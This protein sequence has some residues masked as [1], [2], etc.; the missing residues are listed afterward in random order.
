[1]LVNPSQVADPENLSGQRTLSAG[2]DR[3]LG[4]K[5][6]EQL[7][8]VEIVR[9]DDRGNGVRRVSRV[10]E[11]LEAEGPD[12]FAGPFRAAVVTSEDVDHS[13]VFH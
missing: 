12:A 4:P 3:P 10:G 6:R 1:M 11:K 9:R 5:S 8:H 2:E 7:P 13:L